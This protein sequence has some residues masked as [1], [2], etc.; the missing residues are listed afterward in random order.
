M[1]MISERTLGGHNEVNAG[2]VLIVMLLYVVFNGHV[3]FVNGLQK[4]FVEIIP[5]GYQQ[6]DCQT[7]GYYPAR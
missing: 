2:D 6:Y 5:A 7:N 1:K 4:H 3:F